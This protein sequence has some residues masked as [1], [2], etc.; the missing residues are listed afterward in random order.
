MAS[1]NRPTNNTV[2]EKDINQKLQLYGIYQA[3]ANGKVP[4][5]KQIDVALNSALASKALSSPSP[6]LSEE[7]RKLVGDLKEVIRQAKYLL[8]SKNEGNLL[9]E[10][11][12]DAQHLDGSNANLPKA[13]MD[14]T[15]A[16]QHGDQALEGLKTLGRLIL[17]NGQFRKLLNDA[18]ILMRDMAGDAAQ[19]VASR[20][21]P[22]EDQLNQIDHP[23]EDNTWHDV[24]DLSRESLKNQ[25]RDAYNQNKPFSREEAKDAAQQGVDTAQ[26]HPSQDNQEAG[27][28]GLQ[29]ATEIL[30]DRAR[31]NI[32]DERQE[33]VKKAKEATFQH[34]KNYMDKKIPQERRDQT[35]WR[36]KKMVVEIQ[37]HSDYRQAIDTLLSLAET[38]G[39]HA[40]NLTSQSA[41]TVKGAHEDDRLK[42]AEANLKTLIERFANYTSTDDF[43][44]ALNNIYRDAD[45]DPELKDWFGAVDKY[46]R[47]C[48]Q[49]QGYILQDAANEEYNRLHDEGRFLLRDR[50]RDHTDRVLDEIKFLGDQFD[51]D[52][53]NKA[54]GDAVTKMFL[55]LGN[56]ENGKPTFKPHLIKDLTE[57][58]IPE[59][60][61]NTRYIPIPRIEVSDPMIDAVVE[62]L[63]I[64]SDNLFPNVLEFGS[65]NYFRMGR[66]GISNKR[67]NKVTIAGSGV[68]MDLQDVAYYIK[69]K[70]GFPSITDK[71]VMDIFLG[72]EGFSFKISA[73]NATATDRSHFVAVDKVDV[74]IKH[75]NVKIKQSNHKLLFKIA[76]PLVLKTMKPAIQKVLEK[77]IK[78]A[79]LKADAFAFSVHQDVERAKQATKDDP[80]NA[81]NIWQAYWNS[82]QKILTEKK[83][84]AKDVASKTNVNMAM[85]KQDAMFK[86]INLPGG[87]ST[88][89]TEYKE[90]AAKGDRW[91]SPIFSIGDAKESTDIPKP[92]SV[93]R[94]PHET[95]AGIVR[96]GNHPHSE[97]N[98][99]SVTGTTVTS[100]PAGATTGFSNQVD[101]AF[102]TNKDIT[103]G[104]ANKTYY[105][106]VT[107][108]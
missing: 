51:Q 87:V 14:K 66:K 29:N 59:I 77:Q 11:I 100:N 12:W 18:T 6:K 72:G 108:H 103:N 52:P 96:G 48:L 65:D 105:D 8:L 54:F 57:V 70:Q 50:Y 49:E 1:V 27:R 21:N 31:Q 17:S 76:K 37:G 42:R 40:N 44:D 16:Q 80:E 7:G 98:M 58:I 68:Q 78:D 85:T 41:G 47:K 19:N 64:E 56:D 25:A 55:D 60:F 92:Q 2:K 67:E 30:R 23:A 71:G 32:P 10:F 38:Y 24:P 35:I 99:S 73:R 3:F 46:I 74:T 34:T 33:D 83:E 102:D 88:K 43:F 20:V 91:E 101:R 5:N 36:L 45:R 93:T 69:K 9:Q 62:N 61:E 107:S 22:S 86:H 53:Q 63:V 106:G 84:K 81:P 90:L 89:A 28:A 104:S 26:Q 39:G 97:D 82:Y 15:T 95:A 4:S 75:L 79:F 13:P 94:K